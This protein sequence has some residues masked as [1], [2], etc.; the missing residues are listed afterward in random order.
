M[1][2]GRA[3]QEKG[4]LLFHRACELLALRGT[5]VVYH[6]DHRG[7]PFFPEEQFILD[8]HIGLFAHPDV[9][10]GPNYDPEAKTRA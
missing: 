8:G 2:D 9:G 4:A 3:L 1:L 7:T 10:G 6:H 5:N